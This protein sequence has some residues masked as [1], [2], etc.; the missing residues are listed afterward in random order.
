MTPEDWIAH[1]PD[2]VTAA[3]LAACGGAE[4]AARFAHPL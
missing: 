1:D 4:L 2:P 3:E